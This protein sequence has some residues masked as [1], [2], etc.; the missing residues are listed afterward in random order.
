[1]LRKW[2]GQW[3]LVDTSL[4]RGSWILSSLLHFLG[5]SSMTLRAFEHTKRYLTAR[6]LQISSVRV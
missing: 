1:M 2:I 6:A 3:Y 5:L 4:V